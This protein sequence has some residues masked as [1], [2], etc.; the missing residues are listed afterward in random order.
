MDAMLDAPRPV[1]PG[2]ELDAARLDQYLD[3]HL[4]GGTGPIHVEQFPCGFSNLT[5][6]ITRGRQ[7]L[8]LR[9]PPFGNPVKTAHDMGREYRV[10]SRL[11][12]V[13]P[14]APR[15]LLYCDEP[16]VLGAPFYLMERRR[17]I[18]LRSATPPREL[19]SSPDVVR[20]LVDSFVDQLCRL[21]ALDYEQIGLGDLGKP[22]GYIERQIS[23]WT[24]RYRKAQTDD[25]PDMERVA[26]W[27]GE[28]RPPDGR[29]S[30]I[31]NDYKYDNLLLDR[32]DP[33]RIVAVFDWEMA[34]IGDPL[35]DLGTT[36]AYW[37]EPTDPPALRQYAFGPT[38]VTGSLSRRQLVERYAEQSGRAVQNV[39]FY[40]SYGLFKLAVIVQQI[41][42][43][44]VRGHTRDER[45]GKLNRMVETLA[46]WAINAIETE[47]FS[48]GGA[49]S[50]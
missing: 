28:H 47:T 6:L 26:E 15:P 33:T 32:D 13:Y 25:W 22:N 11:C 36:L 35:M 23:G 39:L 45:F 49:E 5:Y 20:R 41:Y 18:V 8:V 2:E 34:T 14:P 24:E 4:P 1:R 10:L 16:D 37:I 50:T 19:H 27:L 17:G 3:Q 7:E 31:H 46:S 44:Y 9:R 29:P 48:C 30:L 38:M 12:H 42:V 21:H 40:Y 43:R